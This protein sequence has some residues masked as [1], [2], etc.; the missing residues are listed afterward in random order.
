MPKI[1]LKQA[2]PLTTRNDY[3]S[4]QCEIGVTIEGKELPNLE[5]AGRALEL[6]LTQ[7]KS[8]IKD[9]YKVPERV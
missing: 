2:F 3:T 7:F 5:V 4:V 8:A 1:A 6:A 9:S